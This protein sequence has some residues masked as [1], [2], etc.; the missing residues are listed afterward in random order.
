MDSVT[1]QD[2]HF[3][4]HEPDA[5]DG[6]AI[7]N[8][9]TSYGIPFGGSFLVGLQS[10]KKVISR[11]ELEVLMKLCLKYCTEDLAGSPAQVVDSEGGIGI[12]GGTAPLLTQIATQY[13][14]F[15]TEWWRAESGLNSLPS[16]SP[17]IQ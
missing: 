14:V 12:I 16:P 15:F 17:T 10:Q 5:W 6:C 4:F 11:D 1:I 7:F 8:M 3:T 9:I 13:M 2:R